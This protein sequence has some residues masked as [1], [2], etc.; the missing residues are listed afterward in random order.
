M[1][2]LLEGWAG[3]GEPGNLGKTRREAVCSCRWKRLGFSSTLCLADGKNCMLAVSLP[4]L[5]DGINLPGREGDAED[6]D[7]ERKNKKW[8]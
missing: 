6:G 7:R 4:G 2:L 3:V 8:A 1:C 5:T